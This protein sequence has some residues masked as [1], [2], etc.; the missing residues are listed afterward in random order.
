MI[1]TLTIPTAVRKAQLTWPPNSSPETP[2][3]GATTL[4]SSQAQVPADYYNRLASAVVLV[5]SGITNAASAGPTPEI[6][7]LLVNGANQITSSNAPYASNVPYLPQS[8]KLGYAAPLPDEPDDSPSAEAIAEMRLLTGFTWD[9]IAR[10]FAV[11]R[12]SVHLWASGGAMSREN[13]EHL[14]RVLGIVRR[15]DCGRTSSIRAAL[16]TAKGSTTQCPFDLL[17]ARDYDTALR[18]LGSA[19]DVP[20][21]F[22]RQFVPSQSILNER[23]PLPPEVLLDAKHDNGSMTPRR[24]RAVRYRKVERDS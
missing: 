21:A 19:I 13:E 1:Q 18:A 14:H 8:T 2:T 22:A 3:W 6:L 24:A 20:Q 15:S 9:Q 17:I 12:R 23:A 4:T 10:L 11:S 7:H 16:L 5:A